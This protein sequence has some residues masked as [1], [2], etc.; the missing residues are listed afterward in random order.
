VGWLARRAVL[1]IYLTDDIG[2]DL[3]SGV[4]G[5][6]DLR[7]T[8]GKERRRKSI[9]F[10]GN[11]RRRRRMFPRRDVFVILDVIISFRDGERAEPA[12][13]EVKTGNT[14]QASWSLGLA[15]RR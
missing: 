6:L 12:R 15:R 4:S 14:Q 13:L 2:R 9:R 10:R 7:R 3:R 5:G 8:I 1:R 11:G